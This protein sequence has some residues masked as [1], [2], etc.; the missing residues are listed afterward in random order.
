[1]VYLVYN[2]KKIIMFSMGFLILL[3]GCWYLLN[4]AVTEEEVNAPVVEVELVQQAHQ[5]KVPEAVKKQEFFVDCRL[6]RD[7]MRSQ[8]VDV[9]K[10]IAGNPASSVETRDHAQ[11]QLM[12]ITERTSRS[13]TGKTGGCP[14]F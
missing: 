6:T 3:A 2:R 11:Q 7:R 8:Q 5:K 9:L 14:G 4:K 13:R 10:E 1:M 12:K